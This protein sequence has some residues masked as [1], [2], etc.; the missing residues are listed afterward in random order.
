[1]T[2]KNLQSVCGREYATRYSHDYKGIQIAFLAFLAFIFAYTLFVIEYNLN[3]IDSI[4]KE[5]VR[6][7]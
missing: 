7:C 1:M 4:L 3:N 6:V 5:K 2:F